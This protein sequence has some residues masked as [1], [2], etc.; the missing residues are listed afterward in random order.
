MNTNIDTTKG[1]VR[2]LAIAVQALIETHPDK[3]RFISAFQRL[4][5]NPADFSEYAKKASGQASE[6]LFKDL[7]EAAG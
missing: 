2:L 3:G 5:N 6:E 4:I 7:L 1:D